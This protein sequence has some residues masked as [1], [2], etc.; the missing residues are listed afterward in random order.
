M[1]NPSRNQEA[2]TGL[3][4]IVIV[5]RH[6]TDR[7]PTFDIS[8]QLLGRLSLR[9]GVV[10]GERIVGR[11]AIASKQTDSDGSTIVTFDMRP[12]ISLTPSRGICPVP[13]NDP[14]IA[15]VAPAALLDMP[16]PDLCDLFGEK[17]P[18]HPVRTSVGAV[19]D[20]FGD[21][22]TSFALEDNG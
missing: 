12:D 22:V 20:D 14:V 21:G 3:R 7:R 10:L 15:N 9:R 2:W 6:Q 16:A 11:R 1:S 5:P 18:S 17:M 19:E 13:I 8:D 4:R